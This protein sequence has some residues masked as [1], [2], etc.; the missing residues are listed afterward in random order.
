MKGKKVGVPEYSVTAALWIRGF[1][2]HDHGV[3]PSDIEWYEGGQEERGPKKQRIAIQ[4]PENI[5]IK[6]TPSDRSLDE[7]LANGEIDALISPTAPPCFMQQHPD[8]DRLWPDYKKVEMDYFRRT[9]LF[10][11]MHTMVIRKEIY[12]AY[13]WVA[14]SLYKAFSQ[15]KKLCQESLTYMGALNCMLPWSVAEYDS[16][17]GLMGEDFW[18]YGVETNR[19]IL[20]TMTQY[21]YEQG[22][23]SRKLSVEE[24]F[25]P[26]TL[27][28]FKY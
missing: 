3:A 21:S 9:K 14:L 16:T 23:S 12:E 11:I 17:V 13:P 1:L 5:R 6:S 2:L 22:L 20:E 19:V 7:M 8:V 10:P 26:S 25:V 15:A 27:V 28:P 24:L 18:P 4:L